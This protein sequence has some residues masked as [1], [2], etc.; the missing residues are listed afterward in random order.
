MAIE[1]HRTSKNARYS[2]VLDYYTY[3]HQEDTKTG[4]YEPILDE[5]G[6][7]IE[8]ENYAVLYITAKGHRAPP[9]RWAAACVRTNRK[10]GK[11]RSRWDRKSHE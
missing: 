3:R 6:L 2:D 4:H 5:Y 9:E 1:T 8:R 10:Y 11:N 7:I